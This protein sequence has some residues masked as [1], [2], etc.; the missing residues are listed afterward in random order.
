VATVARSR[1]L[2]TR[3]KDLRA[4]D[5]RRR[6]LSYPQI[7]AEM[8]CS[9]SGAHQSVPRALADSAREASEEVRQIEAA[10][11][12]DYMRALN[13]VLLAKHYVVSTATGKVAL[14]PETQQPLLDDDPVIRTVLALV[15]VSER[16]AK[17]LGLDAPTR[18]EVITMDAIEAEIS[19]LE[20]EVGRNAGRA[21]AG[22][23]PLSS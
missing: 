16:R 12:D 19:K 11:L 13:R 23:P 18:H 9:L 8:K 15:R 1:S 21:E 7:A 5:Y 2:A 6:G 3:E 4:L 10:R 22:A 14:H 20:A 17:L